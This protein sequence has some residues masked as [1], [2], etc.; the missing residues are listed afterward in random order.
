M[1]AI[2]MNHHVAISSLV[3]FLCVCSYSLVNGHLNHQPTDVL[4]L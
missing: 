4:C 2:N 1:H 3:C